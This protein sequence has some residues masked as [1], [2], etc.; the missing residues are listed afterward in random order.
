MTFSTRYRSI[1]SS[2]DTVNERYPALG[3]KAGDLALIS[4][5]QY[6]SA[7]QMVSTGELYAID[8]LML[9]VLARSM[10]VIDAFLL[11]FDRWNVSVASPLDWILARSGWQPGGPHG[12][13]EM[14]LRVVP[15]KSVQPTPRFARGD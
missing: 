12:G 10:D 5:R 6:E 3:K 11:S 4:D 8:L 15:N 13:K 14:I 7:A 2:Q 1:R 9:S